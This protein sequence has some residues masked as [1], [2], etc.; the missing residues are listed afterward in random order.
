MPEPRLLFDDTY[1]GPRWT[2]GL[3]Y[4]PITTGSVPSGFIIYSNHA[5]PRFAFGTLQYPRPL[6]SAEVAGYELV[7]VDRPKCEVGCGHDV[8]HRLSQPLKEHMA[9]RVMLVCNDCRS[10]MIGHLASIARGHGV[11]VAVRQ[12]LLED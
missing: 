9:P 7:L 11:P 12:E 2:Y 5:D 3:Q 8:T 10:R 6:T 4:R 1:T